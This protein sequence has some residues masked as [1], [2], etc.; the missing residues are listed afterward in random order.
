MREEAA[1]V[2]KNS[3]ENYKDRNEYIEKLTSR[4]GGGEIEDFSINGIDTAGTDVRIAYTYLKDKQENGDMIYLNP[5][6]EKLYTENPFKAETRKFPIN[7]GSVTDYKQIIS[8]NVPDNYTVEEIPQSA[9]VVYGDNDLIFLY[10][11]LASGNKIQLQYS[12]QI[13]KLILLQDTYPDLQ[14]FFAKI[15][16]QSGNQIV[17]K[18]VAL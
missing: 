8:I 9:K 4:L 13:N 10:R 12:L 2:F 16:Q 15:V 17:L 7:F 3:Y 5:L 14:D 11:V 1:L 6:V 18:K